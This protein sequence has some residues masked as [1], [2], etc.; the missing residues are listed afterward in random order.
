MNK[1]ICICKKGTNVELNPQDLNFRPSVYGVII[2]NKKVL[3][4][5]YKDGKY[6]IPGG[7]INKKEKIKNALKREI[8][9][10]TGLKFKG[11]K[12]IECT[13]NFFETKTHGYTHSLRIYYL[14]GNV[15]GVP[16]L[17]NLD[18]HE[19][20]YIDNFEW[21]DIYKIDK[22]KFHR[23]SKK[24]EIIKKAYNLLE[25]NKCAY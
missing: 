22:I 11:E 8:F 18:D 25:D 3:L 19:K 21:V 15:S 20:D 7:G 16:N 13:E 10:E 24:S 4:I 12:I 1:I 2:K 5:K 14:L 17:N 6:V 9:E 23:N